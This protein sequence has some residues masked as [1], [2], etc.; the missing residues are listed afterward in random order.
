MSVTTAGEFGHYPPLPPGRGEGV[1]AAFKVA[2]K[3]GSVLFRAARWD[4]FGERNGLSLT[5]SL[6][7][8]TPFGNPHHI[9]PRDLSIPGGGAGGKSH[10]KRAWILVG[11]F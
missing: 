7:M 3:T 2:L 6:K 10:K 1:L 5:G 9:S 8:A 4:S 11:N